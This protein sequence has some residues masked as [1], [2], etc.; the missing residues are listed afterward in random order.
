MCFNYQSQGEMLPLKI[1]T[2][3]RSLEV[4]VLLIPV[5]S[6]LCRGKGF[7]T[8]CNAAAVHSLVPTK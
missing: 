4:D 3:L 2:K 1:F 6:P 8:L 5:L 7:L